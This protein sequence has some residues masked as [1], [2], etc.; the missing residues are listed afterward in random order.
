MMLNLLEKTQIC[1]KKYGRYVEYKL[2]EAV[3]HE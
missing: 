2:T 3:L 1:I